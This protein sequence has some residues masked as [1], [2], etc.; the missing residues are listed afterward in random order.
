M[1][2]NRNFY[3]YKEKIN[4]KFLTWILFAILL[5]LQIFTLYLVVTNIAKPLWEIPLYVLYLILR[6]FY[7]VATID[8]K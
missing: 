2:T 3:N 7:S 4:M 8:K 6:S 1:E 5:L